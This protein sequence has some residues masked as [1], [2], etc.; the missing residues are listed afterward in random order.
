MDVEKLIKH[1]NK[2]PLEYIQ[3]NIVKFHKNTGIV[4]CFYLFVWYSSYDSNNLRKRGHNNYDLLS[5]NINLINNNISKNY[6]NTIIHFNT[7]MSKDNELL[8]FII[9]QEKI[10]LN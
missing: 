10:K 3:D 5:N 8:L 2:Y 1:F 4:G 9:K 7:P 6:D